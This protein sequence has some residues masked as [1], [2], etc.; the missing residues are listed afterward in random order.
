MIRKGKL[1]FCVLQCST[2][3]VFTQPCCFLLHVHCPSLLVVMLMKYIK[4]PVM[5]ECLSYKEGVLIDNFLFIF[6]LK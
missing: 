2:T 3:S 6:F 1:I 4:C 5:E